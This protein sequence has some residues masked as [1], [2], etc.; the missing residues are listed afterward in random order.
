MTNS[1]SELK[2]TTMSDEA[3]NPLEQLLRD[4]PITFPFHI[5]KYSVGVGS[6]APTLDFSCDSMFLPLLSKRSI[7][8]GATRI[9]PPVQIVLHGDDNAVNEAQKDRAIGY[10][11][12]WEATKT[13]DGIGDGHEHI[14]GRV[15]VSSQTFN[16]ILALLVEHRRKPNGIPYI[17]LEA[18]DPTRDEGKSEWNVAK[19]PTIQVTDVRFIL[20]D[21]D[22]TT[23]TSEQVAQNIELA[24]DVKEIREQIHRGVVIRLF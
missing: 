2:G 10:L 20:P 7:V 8:K 4:W 1:R 12:Y 3:L 16:T 18:K 6:S 9:D 19:S 23:D 11:K 5:A 14:E 17:A 24:S 15:A 21:Q 13:A 22:M